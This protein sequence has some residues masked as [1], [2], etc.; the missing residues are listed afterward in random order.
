[1]LPPQPRTLS[2]F[3]NGGE[4]AG[5]GSTDH[6]FKSHPE[7]D[8]LNFCLAPGTILFE[9]SRAMDGVVAQ[10]VEHQNGILGVR[11]SNPLGSTILNIGDFSTVSVG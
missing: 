9:H 11:G 2:P 1:M 7:A 3:S 10:L 8:F 5:K 6:P 4:G